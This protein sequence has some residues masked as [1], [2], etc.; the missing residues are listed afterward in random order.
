MR[1]LYSFINCGMGI[2]YFGGYMYFSKMTGILHLFSG[3]YIDLLTLVRHRVPI[4]VLSR[5]IIN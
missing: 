3:F 5:S 4:K 1:A 2:M